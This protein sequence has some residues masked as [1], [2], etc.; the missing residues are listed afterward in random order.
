MRESAGVQDDKVDPVDLSLLDPVNEFM[1]GVALKTGKVVSEFIG[2]L[3]AA[4][5]DVGET[6]RA[7]DI[8]FT[9]TQQIQV[10]S[11]DEQKGGHFEGF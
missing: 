4:F 1:F 9:R 6:G 7:V 11:V 3:N 5:F 2:T 8:R 10:G